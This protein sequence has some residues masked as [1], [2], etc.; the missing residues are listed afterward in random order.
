MGVVE[1]ASVQLEPLHTQVLALVEFHIIPPATAELQV[2][3]VV[4]LTG[5]IIPTDVVVA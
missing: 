4:V 2:G 1:V 3:A 5:E